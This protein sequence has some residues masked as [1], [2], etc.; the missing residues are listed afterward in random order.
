[1]FSRVSRQ[2]SVDEFEGVAGTQKEFWAW[3]PPLPLKGV[4]VFV[5]PPRSADALKHFVSLSFLWSILI[6]FGGI[7]IFTWVYLQPA[8]ERCVEFHAD[9]ILQM[10][11]RNLGLMFVVAGGLH[12]YFY[13]QVS[14]FKVAQ[15]QSSRPFTHTLNAG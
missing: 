2:A 13:S 15:I 7:A 1:M 11:A 5:W 14:E 8:L 12:L 9:W 4:P 10:Y 3:H 6:P